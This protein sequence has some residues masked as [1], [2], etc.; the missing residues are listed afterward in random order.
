MNEWN[1][2]ASSCSLLEYVEDWMVEVLTM[3]RR[4]FLVHELRNCSTFRKSTISVGSSLIFVIRSSIVP[5]TRCSNVWIHYLQNVCDGFFLPFVFIVF[6]FFFFFFFSLKKKLPFF[7]C[8]FFFFFFSVGFFSPP[9]PSFFFFFF[10]VF[11]L[12]QRN[13]V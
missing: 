3:R 9:L 5:P 11:F 7:F 12:K 8:L 4:S 10:L 13:T 6:F 2:T 1:H